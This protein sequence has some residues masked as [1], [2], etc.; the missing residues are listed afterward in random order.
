MGITELLEIDDNIRDMLIEGE[1]SEHIKE[2]ACKENGMLTLWDDAM[3][4]CVAGL[5]PLEEVLRIASKD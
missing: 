2:Y 1:S 5:T 3:A 4:K